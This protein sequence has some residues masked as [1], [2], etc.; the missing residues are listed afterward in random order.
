MHI[1]MGLMASYKM[2][3]DGVAA[4]VSSWGGLQLHPHGIVL[5]AFH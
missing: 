4:Y 5:A 3:P 2:H 1:L